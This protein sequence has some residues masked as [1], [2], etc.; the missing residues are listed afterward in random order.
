MLSVAMFLEAAGS[1]NVLFMLPVPSVFFYP[2]CMTKVD[3]HPS[4]AQ[5]SKQHFLAH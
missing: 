2:I 5:D 1:V 3:W 4:P